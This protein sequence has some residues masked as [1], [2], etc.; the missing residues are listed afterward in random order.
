MRYDHVMIYPGRKFGSVEET[1]FLSLFEQY[2]PDR[3]LL[4][5]T[6]MDAPPEHLQEAAGEADIL[7]HKISELGARSFEDALQ[8]KAQPYVVLKEIFDGICTE[9]PG[10]LGNDDPE[11]PFI[12]SLTSGSALHATL[13]L[14]LGIPLNA[15]FVSIEARSRQAEVHAHEWIH[16][17]MKA[18]HGSMQANVL[19][20]ILINSTQRGY[21]LDTI[22]EGWLTADEIIGG[23]PGDLPKTLGFSNTAEVLLDDDLLEKVDDGEQSV[24]ARNQSKYNDLSS[25]LDLLEQKQEQKLRDLKGTGVADE[26]ITELEQEIDNLRYEMQAVGSKKIALKDALDKSVK[27]TQG[28]NEKYRL[29]AAGWIAAIR[30]LSSILETSG[31]P[32]EGT[33]LDTDPDLGSLYPQN[34]RMIRGLICGIRSKK[35]VDHVDL[36]LKA[37]DVLRTLDSHD[38]LISIHSRLRYDMKEAGIYIQDTFNLSYSEENTTFLQYREE[39]EKELERRRIH[40][41]HW[42]FFDACPSDLEEAFRVYCEW[43]WPRIT[44]KIEDNLGEDVPV[45]WS[46]D[47]N[48][49]PRSQMICAATFA[50]AWQNPMTYVV[51][52]YGEPGVTQREVQPSPRSLERESH[53]LHLPDKLLT[54]L[55]VSESRNWNHP[56]KALIG[57]LVWKEKRMELVAERNQARIDTPLDWQ[58]GLNDIDRLEIGI[59]ALR[60]KVDVW[61]NSGNLSEEYRLVG[62]GSG[63]QTAKAIRYLEP[64]GLIECISGPDGSRLMRLTDLGEFL[65]E[66]L[67]ELKESHQGDE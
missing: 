45:H 66:Y 9:L 47:L 6:G 51:K 62:E 29:T 31:T 59:K 41:D 39:R 67:R 64:K 22:S 63:I 7:F 27:G 48:Q 26:R 14:V 56:Q 43:L 1:G 54:D 5:H 34:Q 40:Q 55:M 49:L 61:V 53:I 42:A 44:S 25:E 58:A 11:D 3:I 12:I 50:H 2:P 21:N 8:M 32:L 23:L 16:L 24:I 19:R 4:L 10:R 60:D 18:D 57:L 15:L 20:A 13:L 46:L 30:A 38:A 52:R 28:D 17:G 37:L 35:D 33:S 36:P 65:A